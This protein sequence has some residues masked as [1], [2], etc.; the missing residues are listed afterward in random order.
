MAN[1]LFPGYG[2]LKAL[3]SLGRLNIRNLLKNKL[4]QTAAGFIPGAGPVI[5]KAWGIAGDALNK[6][7]A[8]KQK[9]GDVV[10]VGKDAYQNLASTIPDAQNEMEV[11]KASNIALK[12]AINKQNANK[13][14]RVIDHRNAVDHRRSYPYKNRVKRIVPLQPNSRVAIFPR[15]ISIN[16]R[17]QVIP[18]KP[19]SIVV[20]K[21]DKL[22]IWELK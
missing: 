9:I 6:Y 15:R 20:V 3:S 4:L 10:Q 17:Q 18:I 5:S 14:R 22:I 1:L 13:S 12:N 11:R 16:R 8:A 2:A 19:N 7:D 21:N